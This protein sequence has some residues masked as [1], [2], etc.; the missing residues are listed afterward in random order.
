MSR[1]FIDPP[2]GSVPIPQCRLT[3]TKLESRMPVAPSSVA[4][5]ITAAPPSLIV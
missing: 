2:V 5:R 4:S 3:A 1:G